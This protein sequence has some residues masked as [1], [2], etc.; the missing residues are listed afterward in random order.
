MKPSKTILADYA[1]WNH[2]LREQVEFSWTGSLLHTKEHCARVL[3]LCLMIAD[4]RNLSESE[5]RTL[6]QAA[7]FH[8]ARRQDDCLDVGHGQR[9]AAYYRTY[10][11]EH[12]MPFDACTYYIMS[13]H[14]RDDALGLDAL[15]EHLSGHP[16]AILLYQIFKDADAL[17]RF[18]LGPH[19]LDIRY[20][21][22]KQARTLVEFAKSLLCHGIQTYSE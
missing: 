3:L 4:M 14:D 6:A 11:Q 5:K 10:C 19:A 18:R 8:D 12:G 7:C 9:A 17:D 2:F 15:R 22:T 1:V 16:D 20:L 13:Y 21:R